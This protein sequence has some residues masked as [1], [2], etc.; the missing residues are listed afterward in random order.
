MVVQR[1]EQEKAIV[2]QQRLG[3]HPLHSRSATSSPIRPAMRC[4]A[5]PGRREIPEAVNL[6]GED[7]R[8]VDLGRC[9]RNGDPPEKVGETV[10]E[11]PEDLALILSINA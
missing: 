7:F 6:D 10:L 1:R 8:L 2:A 11:L 5:R 9:V 3:S 4:G